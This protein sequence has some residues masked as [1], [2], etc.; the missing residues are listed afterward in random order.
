MRIAEFDISTA[1][2]LVGYCDVDGARHDASITIALRKADAGAKYK[3]RICGGY[4]KTGYLQPDS[5]YS[6]STRSAASNTPQWE[7]D[8]R[9]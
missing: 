2:P 5:G 4:D 9:S 1:N 3:A 8:T 7:C 6:I